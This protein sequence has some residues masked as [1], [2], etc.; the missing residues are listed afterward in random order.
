MMEI[1]QNGAL[2]LA[3][4]LTFP[5]TPTGEVRKVGKLTPKQHPHHHL[6]GGVG[7][8]W[9]WREV[10][11][12]QVGKSLPCRHAFKCRLGAGSHSWV[13]FGREVPG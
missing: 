7:V 13:A 6:L 3:G 9:G 10:S 4:N 11:F 12:S 2:P 8:W 1:Q 5:T